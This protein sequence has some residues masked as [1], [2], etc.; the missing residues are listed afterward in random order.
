MGLPFAFIG[1]LVPAVNFSECKHTVLEIR[2]CD[3][4]LMDIDDPNKTERFGRC[5]RV[6]TRKVKIN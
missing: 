3:Y 2:E 4:I 5:Q 1:I 6:R